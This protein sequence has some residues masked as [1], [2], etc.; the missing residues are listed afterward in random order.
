M[1]LVKFLIISFIC[2]KAHKKVP[3]PLI[4]RTVI[5][6]I[7]TQFSFFIMSSILDSIFLLNYFTISLTFYV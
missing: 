4:K 2:A 6:I 5:I 1:R 3:F 7:I